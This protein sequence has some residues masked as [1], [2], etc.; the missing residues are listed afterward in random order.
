MNDAIQTF[1]GDDAQTGWVKAMARGAAKR[2]PR[3]GKGRLYESYVKVAPACTVCGLDF[4]GHQADDAPPYITIFLVGHVT[5]PLALAMKQLFEPPLWLQ[6]VIWL[7]IILAATFWLLPLAK[8]ALIG[9]QWANRMHG[10][11]EE[12]DGLPETG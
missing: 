10:F 12:E 8:G 7:P 6:F 9:L 4:S 2:C 1:G 11:G 5:I 3:C